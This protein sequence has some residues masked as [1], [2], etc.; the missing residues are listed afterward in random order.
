MK[1]TGLTSHWGKEGKDVGPGSR[2]ADAQP[3]QGRRRLADVWKRS[4]RWLTRKIVFW[5]HL[6]VVLGLPVSELPDEVLE[7]RMPRGELALAVV[8]ER[9]CSRMRKSRI[10]VSQTLRPGALVGVEPLQDAEESP[11]VDEVVGRG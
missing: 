4:R 9:H 3:R 7:A 6:E 10:P 5:P 1:T 8:R 11:D 2:D